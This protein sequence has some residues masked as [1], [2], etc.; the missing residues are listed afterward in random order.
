MLPVNE[1]QMCSKLWNKTVYLIAFQFMSHVETKVHTHQV[2]TANEALIL[3]EKSEKG[4]RE[5]KWQHE[6]KQAKQI[7]G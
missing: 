6:V 3:W 4:K 1:M 7:H 5:T 2:N